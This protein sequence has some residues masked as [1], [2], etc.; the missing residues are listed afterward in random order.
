MDA[1]VPHRG[2][3]VWLAFQPQAAHEQSGH[4]PALVLSPRT[5]NRRT[6][7]F[8]ACPITS[9]SKGYPFEVAIPDGVPVSGVVLSDQIKSLDWKARQ[10]SL[11]GRVSMDLVDEVVAL[12]QPLIL[13]E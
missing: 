9:K 6:G 12:I 8:L 3:L 13:G 7:L 11:A 2:D 1:Y 10:A 4:R 5:Y